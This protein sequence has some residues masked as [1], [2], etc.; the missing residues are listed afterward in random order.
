MSM[1]ESPRSHL[2]LPWTVQEREDPVLEFDHG[3]GMYFFDRQGRCYLD[4]LSQLFQG[5]LGH[6]NRRVI[7]ATRRQAERSCC[8]SPQVL[9]PERAALAE[10]LARRAPGDLDRC[11]FV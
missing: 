3:E 10:A 4:F 8:V 2:L 9:T 11:F 6:G 1:R 7:E 5:N